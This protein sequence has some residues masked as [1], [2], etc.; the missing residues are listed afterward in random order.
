[1]Q[2]KNVI[3]FNPNPVQKQF[4]ESRATADLFSSR[5][6]E[7]KSAALVWSTLYHTRHNPGAE[8]FLIRDTWENLMATTQKEF[9]Y[10]FPPGVYGDYHAGKKVFT[11][12]SGI[13]EGSVGFLGMDAP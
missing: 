3:T 13:A 2:D 12:A 8:W 9:F 7:G 4:I 10:W 11:W 1:M 6:G 5:M